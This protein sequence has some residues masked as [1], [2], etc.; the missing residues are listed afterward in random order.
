[1]ITEP[2]VDTSLERRCSLG[3]V[4]YLERN[5]FTSIKVITDQVIQ[6][7]DGTKPVYLWVCVRG[8]QLRI[9]GELFRIAALDHARIDVLVLSP[10]GDLAQIKHLMN[11]VQS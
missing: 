3:I 9:P 10:D 2:S 1:M 11:A 8:P 6:A 7:K 4:S 5:D